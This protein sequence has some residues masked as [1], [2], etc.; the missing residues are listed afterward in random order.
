MLN[1]IDLLQ[2][3]D[4][5][6]QANLFRIRRE[7]HQDHTL[8]FCS[9]DYL[10]LSKHP[11]VLAGLKRAVDC[12]GFGSGSSALVTGYTKAH[13]ELEQFAAE[14]LG[15]ERALLFNSGYMANLGIFKALTNKNSI[16]YADKYCHASLLDGCLL[17]DAKLRRYLHVNIS[18]LQS[19]MQGNNGTKWVVT[20]G[21]FSMSG[22]MAPLPRLIEIAKEQSATLLVDDSHG[23]G[24]LGK[25]GRGC[26]EHY[27]LTAKQIPILICSLGKAVGGFGAI[28]ASNKTVIENLIQ[29]SRTYVYTTAMP[30]AF[31]AAAKISLDILQQ[32]TWR[33]EKIKMLIQYFQTIAKTMG[34]NILP[35]STPIQSIIFSNVTQLLAIQSHLKKYGI[36][37]SAIRPPTVPKQSP[38]LRISLNVNHN[39]YDLEKLI[40]LLKNSHLLREES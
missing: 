5:Y 10:G 38:R 31:A 29:F 8:C 18:S 11:K 2:R 14:F 34:L 36:Q 19:Q 6:K 24:V 21:V 1:K 26:I 27:G 17:S 39:K 12:Y 20:D 3:L 32:E 28:V 40:D 37:V 30:S 33:R 7:N 23:I 13:A 25:N 9:N 22:N 35:S 15:F 16:L 4:A